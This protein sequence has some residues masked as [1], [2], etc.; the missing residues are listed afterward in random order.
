L[1]T[2]PTR[3]PAAGDGPAPAGESATLRAATA[4]GAED[5]P[6]PSEH[7][8]PG[9]SPREEAEARAGMLG[10][11]AAALAA[12]SVRHPVLTLVLSVL[13]GLGSCY[14]VATRFALDTDVIRMF[15]ENL[16]WRQAEKAI[17]AAF[18]QREDVIAIVVD[19]ATP[20]TAERAAAALA[21][22]LRK[23]TRRLE[24]VRRPDDAEVLRRSALLFPDLEKVREAT[25]R[26]IAAQP[27]LGTLAAD[28]TLRGIAG[29]LEL[30]AQAMERGEANGDPGQVAYALTELGDAAEAAAAGRVAPL[31][32]SQLFTGRAPEALAL[33]RFVLARPK[34]DY[35]NLAP[36][37]AATTAIRDAI[38]RLGL[39]AEAGVRVRMTGNIVMRDEEFST[40]F[41]G[42]ISENLIS[43]FSVAGLLWLGLRSLR[44]ITPMLGVLVLGLVV[45]AAF[46]ALVVGP[47]N[48]LSIAFAVLFIGLGVDFAIHYAVCLREQRLRLRTEPLESA[49]VTAAAIAG[50]A[51]G[52]AA[53]ALC[54]GF[55]A[56]LPTDYRGVSE[57]GVIA[58]AGMI[59]AVIISLTT[60]P[61]WLVFTR[62]QEERQPVG[63]AG[64]APL[65]R[66][67]RRRARGVFAATIL[68]ALATA[69]CLPYLRFDTNPLNLRDP[70]TEAV[71]TFRDLMRD[72]ETTPN[73][74][75]ILVRDMA[76]AKALQAR[77]AQV[78]EVSETWTIADFVPSDQEPKL[79]L[80]RDA[81]DLMGPTLD[82][83]V[84]EAPPDDAAAA[85]ALGAAAD[86]LLR[87]AADPKADPRLAAPAERLGKA[88]RTVA[89]GPP[90]GRER[91]RESLVPG[92]VTTLDGLRLALAPRPV[93]IEDLPES[94][95]RDWVTADGRVRV[96]VRPRD[97]SDRSDAMS[98]FA[99][100]VLAVDPAASGPAISVQAS[101]HTIGNAFLH[102][103]FIATGLTVVLLL[104]ALR[105]WRLTILALAPLALA[106]LLT[107]ATCAVIGLP[108][109]L[110]NIVA[111]PLL[112]AQG[113]AFKIY[114]VIAWK[115]GERA[116]L[117]SALTRAVLYSA[118]T[119]G[120]AFGSL[121][122]SQHPGTAGMGVMLTMS[123]F[124]ALASVM[125]VLPSLLALFAADIGA[126]RPEE[127]VEEGSATAAAGAGA[128]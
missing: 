57:L 40:V 100:A 89:D 45:T 125:L 31:D 94:M 49:L 126:P 74:I 102:A 99:N 79:A 83:P 113:V 20:D 86:A 55:L 117:P 112:F 48:P 65:D 122:L 75:Q 68:V 38:A 37:N 121:A 69:A 95:R 66:F 101:S 92:L 32:W 33:R 8:G 7:H 50:P 64:L 97:L 46:G 118:L 120:T 9:R 78:P 16:A 43:L 107:L 10:R 39:N 58:A 27:M 61:A 96:E 2:V 4:V 41:G 116:L 42:A 53:L 44:L 59:I 67:L 82:P 77:L 103:G 13:L 76:A 17:D 128:A 81:A 108:L 127:T 15:P 60:L 22:E 63:Y 84:T 105:S 115:A 51:I 6:P 1:D 93:T 23:E 36:G 80:V 73:T 30:I 72:P 11:L 25:E 26:I 87:A 24:D 5:V 119:N 124:Y 14:A 90:E 71:S 110:A 54:A 70:H 111:L 104:V 47:Y 88:L 52:L 19:G 91:L 12:V 18:P 85:Q 106:G 56:F 21:Q 62:P 114:F 34:L 109:N 3:R 98:R 35:S 28:P 29:T 123:L